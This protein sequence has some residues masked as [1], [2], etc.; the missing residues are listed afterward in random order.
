MTDV[1]LGTKSQAKKAPRKK[2]ADKLAQLEKQQ[3]QLS[4][5]IKD[6]KAKLSKKN[7]ALETRRKI[8]AGAIALTHMEHDPN[9][10]NVMEGLLKKHVKESDKYLFEI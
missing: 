2:P 4:A 1:N 3:A 7:R 9:F 5:R 8:V 6:E 10:K